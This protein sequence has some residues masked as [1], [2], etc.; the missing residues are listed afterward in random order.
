[1]YQPQERRSQ[2]VTD[3]GGRGREKLLEGDDSQD[4]YE[5]WEGIIP[6]SHSYSRTGVCQ[7]TNEQAVGPVYPEGE[8]QGEY[9]VVIV[10][11][12]T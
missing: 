11:H 12:G 3:L 1:M 7:Y 4:R 8:D 10:L 9:P 2:T 5:T 6:T